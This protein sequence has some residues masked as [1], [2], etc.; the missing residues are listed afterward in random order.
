MGGTGGICRR[1]CRLPARG[2]VSRAEGK[3]A[4]WVLT[5]NP[6]ATDSDRI[7]SDLQRLDILGRTVREN[8]LHRP[9]TAVDEP[10]RLSTSAEE[11]VSRLARSPDDLAVDTGGSSPASMSWSLSASGHDTSGQ[12]SPLSASGDARRLPR[13]SEQVIPPVELLGLLEAR[14]S[15]DRP[16]LL[17][18]DIRPM[19]AF[20][21][22]HLPHSANVVIPSM[23]LRRCKASAGEKWQGGWGALRGFISSE[24]GRDAWDLAME[25]GSGEIMLVLL[26]ASER[27]EDTATA[28]T[29]EVLVRKLAAESDLNTEDDRLITD[30]WLAGGW[31]EGI[32]PVDAFR[33]LYREGEK[34]SKARS[35]S[36]S[37]SGNPLSFRIPPAIDEAA[38]ADGIMV[39]TPGGSLTQ[40][41]GIFSSGMQHPLGAP[42]PRKTPVHHPSLPALHLYPGKAEHAPPPLLSPGFEASRSAKRQPPRPSPINT[43]GIGRRNSSNDSGPELS[44]ISEPGRSMRPPKLSL[45]TAVH[46]LPLKSASLGAASPWVPLMG[47]L[48]PPRKNKGPG[49][50]LTINRSSAG[51]AVPSS[52]R[53]PAQPSI[54]AACHAQSRMTPSPSSFGG[55]TRRLRQSSTPP[56]NSPS[57]SP[58]GMTARP[59]FGHQLT[60]YFRSP[61]SD[62]AEATSPGSA[63]EDDREDPH[64]DSAPFIVSTVLPQFLY[65]GPEITTEADVQKLKDLGVKRIL[66]V[67]MECNDAESLRIPERFDKYVQLPLRDTVEETGI[68]KGVRDACTFLGES[69]DQVVAAT[70]LRYFL[71][72]P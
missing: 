66:N 34:S 46:P 67:A 17:I 62:G 13:T 23:I 63:S 54:H 57:T 30:K 64:R 4:R 32:K 42:P 41:P 26:N 31:A 58:S 48:S 2:P 43:S 55:I 44:S 12:S 40:S 28:D 72:D 71:F 33:P 70:I 37:R 56:G 14:S 10:V 9:V 27:R 1:P 59:D 6:P 11:G 24:G 18:L 22:S 52:P 69:A 25:A 5:P 53:K 7:T 51:D 8:L 60:S 36:Q 65:L 21:V 45:N 38:A 15:A 39:A 19:P 49:L 47:N 16:R 61:A 20:L 68:G 3:L 35:S 29:I 50:T